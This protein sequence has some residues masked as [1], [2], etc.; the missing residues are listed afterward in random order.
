MKQYPKLYEDIQDEPQRVKLEKI[1]STFGTPEELANKF[2]AFYKD[3]HRQ[4]FDI[5][6]KQIWLEQHFMYGED[7]RK[8]RRSNG[9]AVDTAYSYFMRSTVG[10][11]HRPVAANESFTSLST[12]LVDF[13]PEFLKKDPFVDT[14][15]YAYP[16]KNIT[17]DHLAFVYQMV[18]DRLDMLKYADEKNMNSAEFFNWATN[19]ALCMNDE[20]GEEQYMLTISDFNW[21]HIR[22]TKLRKGWANDQFGF[23]E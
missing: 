11:S 6:V 23:K 18:D 7:R 21:P 14:D 10:I 2:R 20:M 16:F 8:K 1:T 9:H 17:L 4:L 22:N 19:H 13:F 12:Y 3:A 5:V 15:Y